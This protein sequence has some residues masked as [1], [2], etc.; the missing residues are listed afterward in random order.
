MAGYQLDEDVYECVYLGSSCW[1]GETRS[2]SRA[3]VLN[4]YYLDTFGPEKT[5]FWGEFASRAD[6]LRAPP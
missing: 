3:Q 5:W 1:K 2:I 6:L 4:A